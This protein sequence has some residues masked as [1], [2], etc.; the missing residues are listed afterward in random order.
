VKDAEQFRAL[1]AYSPYHHVRDGVAYPPILLLTGA[2]DARVNPMHSRKMTARLQAA[3]ARTVL[4]RT[5]ATSG[6]GLGTSLDEQI[7]Q[8][9]DVLAFLFAQLGMG[10]RRLPSVPPQAGG[11]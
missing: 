5:S 4:L 3:G 11:S 1:H 6:H 2:N 10:T 7:E 8:E 9:V